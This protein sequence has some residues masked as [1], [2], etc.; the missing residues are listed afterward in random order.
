MN[1]NLPEEFCTRMKVMLGQEEYEAFLKS[2]NNPRE[3]GL[4]VNTAKITCEEWE[5]LAPFPMRPI[6]W[7]KNG[8]FYD[9]D[10]QP[11]KLPYYQ[12]GLYYLQEPSAMTP[13]SRLPI[14]PGEY[15]LDMCAAPGGKATAAGALLGGKGLLVANDISTSRARALLRNLELFGITNAFVTNEP[16]EK[17]TRHFPEFFHKIILDAPCSGEGMF[18][19]EEAMIH[20]WSLEKSQELSHIQRQLICQAVSMLRPGG[21]LLYSTCTFAPGEDEEI[22][23]CLLSSHPE[24]ELLDIAPYEGFSEGRPDWG[25]GNPELKKCVRIFPHKMNGEG[26]FLALFRKKGTPKVPD[27]IPVP[28]GKQKKFSKKPGRSP[29]GLDKSTETLIREF[30]QEAGITSLGGNPLSPSDMELRADKV[31]LVPPA[32][33][34]LRGITFLR[35][36]LYLGDIKKNRFEPSQPLALALRKGE[37]HCT[38]SLSINDPRLPHYFKGETICVNP[39]EA[40]VEKGWILLCADGYP[41]GFGKLVGN[42][43]KNKYPAGWRH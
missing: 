9:S 27:D 19:K 6:P 8:Y 40:S 37:C 13:L 15:V 43:L 35:N 34:S 32:S 39:G 11:A 42:T 25:D 29:E 17:L 26:H 22:A 18:R 2:Y 1:T 36:G 14:T 21:L 23:A 3:L 5:T 16:P 33:R 10:A 4:R 41:L 12:A 20:D 30:F 38:L 28:S 24:M 7:T 31:Y